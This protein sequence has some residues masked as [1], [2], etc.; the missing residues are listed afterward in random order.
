MSEVIIVAIIGAAATILAALI[1]LISKSR[2]ANKNVTKIKQKINYGD[3]NT[4]I[5]IQNN[6][7]KEKNNDK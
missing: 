6:Y 7:T 2:S 4:Q 3:N 5:G 1:G